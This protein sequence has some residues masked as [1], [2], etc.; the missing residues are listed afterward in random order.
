M[1]AIALNVN[2]QAA[3]IAEIKDGF[4]INYIYNRKSLYKLPRCNGRLQKEIL[5]VLDHPYCNEYYEYALKQ[6]ILREY[7]IC[8]EKMFHN[9]LQL[10]RRSRLRAA[11]NNALGHL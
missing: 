1:Y 7:V 9:Q 6:R 5:L 10:S 2:E 11:R 8:M 4:I 3:D